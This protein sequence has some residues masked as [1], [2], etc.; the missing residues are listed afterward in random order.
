L[1]LSPRQESVD[2]KKP[3][4][5]LVTVSFMAHSPE[6]YDDWLALTDEQRKE[7]H[8]KEWNVY[9]RDGIT[10]AFMA[11]ARLALQCKRTIL[12]IEIGTYHGGEYL[13]HLTVPYEEHQGCPPMLAESFEGFRVVWLPFRD[14][15][16]P[17]DIPATL[18]GKWRAEQGDYEFEFR[19]TS[20]G[21]D[22]AGKVRTTGEELQIERPIVNGHYVLFSAYDPTS[23]DHTQHSFALVAPDRA[24]DRTT[25]TEYYRRPPG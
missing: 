20:A 19:S 10:I 16:A 17:P 4:T 23:D 22:V 7:V 15:Q 24:Q 9:R 3:A 5:T 18:D 8:F 14:Y 11:A 1:W 21:V 2:A 12:D 13:L 25:R 6:T